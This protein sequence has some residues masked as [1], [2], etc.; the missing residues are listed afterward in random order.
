MFSWEYDS[1]GLF[2]QPAPW[3][4]PPLL[5]VMSGDDVM[6]V[7]LPIGRL[8]PHATT[9]RAGILISLIS[10]VIRDVVDDEG[11]V[12][13]VHCRRKRRGDGGWKMG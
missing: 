3:N 8:P 13:P 12:L 2:R 11:L 6:H 5:T 1:E 4:G 7:H 10:V 9:G